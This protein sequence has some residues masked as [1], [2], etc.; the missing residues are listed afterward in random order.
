[1]FLLSSLFAW[2]EFKE[3]HGVRHDILKWE[4]GDGGYHLHVFSNTCEWVGASSFMLFIVSYFKEF[5]EVVVVTK[6]SS[7]HDYETAST[8]CLSKSDESLEELHDSP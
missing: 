8:S 7:R 3:G 2:Q 6:C 4:P 1:M 5:Q